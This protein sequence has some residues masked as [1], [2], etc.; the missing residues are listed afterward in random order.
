MI[1][2]FSLVGVGGVTVR[3]QTMGSS[4]SAPVAKQ[5]VP[6]VSASSNIKLPESKK[7]KLTQI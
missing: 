2:A 7:K 3:G 1:F 5:P 4:K 6:L